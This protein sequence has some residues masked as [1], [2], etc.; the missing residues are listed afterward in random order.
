MLRQQSWELPHKIRGRQREDKG[1]VPLANKFFITPET[2][3]PLL[4]EIAALVEILTERLKVVLNVD[5]VYVVARAKN[6]RMVLRKNG[7]GVEVF[8]G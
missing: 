6:G 5:S 8:R 2:E 3:D 4:R 7:I 1:G